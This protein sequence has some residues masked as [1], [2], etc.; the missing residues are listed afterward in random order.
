VKITNN[1]SKTSS[2]LAWFLTLSVFFSEH[3]QLSQYLSQDIS[4]LDFSG[5]PNSVNIHL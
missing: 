4:L 5:D 3:I 1:F 2:E